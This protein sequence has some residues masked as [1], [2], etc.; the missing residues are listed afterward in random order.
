MPVSI[1][2]A[3]PTNKVTIDEVKA[4]ERTS[5]EVGARFI[6]SGRWIRGRGKPDVPEIGYIY[7]AGSDSEMDVGAPRA[8][9]LVARPAINGS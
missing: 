8:T 9:N 5:V 4:R 1:L 3:H 7:S 2:S 6:K